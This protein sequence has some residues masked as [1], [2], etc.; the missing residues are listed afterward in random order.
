MFIFALTKL[1]VSRKLHHTTGGE[2]KPGAAGSANSRRRKEPNDRV[3]ILGR[4]FRLI[5]WLILATWL[6]RK[7][8]AWLFGE[9]APTSQR[10][11]HISQPL[12]RDPVCG[13]FVSPKI[14]LTLEQEGHVRHFCS[15]ECRERFAA[16]HGGRAG[17]AQIGISA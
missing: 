9:S 11:P 14:S 7:L 1:R 4:L 12:Q 10:G 8:F 16:A 2:G 6:G 17:A 13:T 3:A 5:F 15:A